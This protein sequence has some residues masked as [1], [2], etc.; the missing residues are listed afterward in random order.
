MISKYNKDK[1]LKEYKVSFVKE[2][3]SKNGVPYIKFSIADAQ[4]KEDGTYSYEN[5]TVFTYQTNFTLEDGD[6]ITFQDIYALKV[7]ESEYEGKRRINR[8]IFATVEAI[9]AVPNRVKVVDNG[10]IFDGISDDTLPF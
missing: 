5:Y 2:G 10:D 3:Q 7:E 9:P 6:K 8:T 4:K 1:S